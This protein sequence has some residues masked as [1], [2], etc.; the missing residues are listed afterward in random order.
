MDAG[1]EGDQPGGQHHDLADDCDQGGGA[2]VLGVFLGAE[3]GNVLVT[4]NP[5]ARAAGGLDG[6]QAADHL[7]DEFLAPGVKLG[8]DFNLA[9]DLARKC[10]SAGDVEQRRE[11]RHDRE[12]AGNDGNRADKDKDE[13]NVQ[14]RGAKGTGDELLDPLKVADAGDLGADAGLFRHC[15]GQGQQ[16]VEHGG[17]RQ[18]ADARAGV[19]DQKAADL[20]HHKVGGKSQPDAGGD[21]DQ[22]GH[23]PRGNDP[24]IGK[25]NENRNAERQHIGQPGQ[26]QGIGPQSAEPADLLLIPV[27]ARFRGGVLKR[28]EGDDR[29]AGGFDRAILDCSG[30]QVVNRYGLRSV[31]G[32]NDK[33]VRG[34]RQ[35]QG[36]QV[37]FRG[38]RAPGLNLAGIA[39]AAHEV[40]QGRDVEHLILGGQGVGKRTGAAV[41]AQGDQQDRQAGDDIVVAL[42]FVDGGRQAGDLFVRI[43]V[44]KNNSELSQR[45]FVFGGGRIMCSGDVRHGRA[46]RFPVPCPG[47]TARSGGRRTGGR[48]DG[49][50]LGST[51]GG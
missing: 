35:H 32:Q 36:G 4:V 18:I 50:C 5:G 1:A 10:D 9:G 30:L 33:G 37:G 42:P 45:V 13:G 7:D 28:V 38:Q 43:L 49:R 26:H 20:A 2:R 31:E 16:A 22:G 24:V 44:L 48:C 41:P 27:Q 23:G 51:A 15:R 6:A 40:L 8:A 29:A 34:R 21:T 17:A 3:F 39:Q 19:A 47:A 25:Q 46:L 11:Q 14:D 12:P